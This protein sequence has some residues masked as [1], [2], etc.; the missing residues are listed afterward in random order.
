MPIISLLTNVPLTKFP[1]SFRK[2]FVDLLAGTL[3]KP[4]E[5]ISLHIASDTNFSYGPTDAEAILLDVK[6]IGFIGAEENITHTKVITKFIEETIG[7]K[8]VE[9]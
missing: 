6:A 8:L 2:S 1:S 9:C 7:I 3:H 4:V 5:G